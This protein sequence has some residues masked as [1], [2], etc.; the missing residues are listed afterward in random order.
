MGQDRT[1][2]D[3][4]SLPGRGL[5]PHGPEKLLSRPPRGRRRGSGGGPGSH[6]GKDVSAASNPSS[7]KNGGL[8]PHQ[9]EVGP[10][11]RAWLGPA[12]WSPGAAGWKVPPRDGAP[13]SLCRAAGPQPRGSTCPTI[14]GLLEG[15]P[16]FLNSPEKT[17]LLC[18]TSSCLAFQQLWRGPGPQRPNTYLGAR[19]P[20][21]APWASLTPRTLDR[22]ERGQVSSNPQR[23]R[24]LRP[25]PAPHAPHHAL[26][27]RETALQATVTVGPRCPRGPGFPGVP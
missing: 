27:S 7:R 10:L 18:G 2:P 19:L 4:K 24:H 20:G 17:P 1:G 11:S 14:H 8:R 23:P 5:L 16:S 21:D 12:P 22:R 3:R 15:S 25:H 9:D 26:L 13:G 6:G